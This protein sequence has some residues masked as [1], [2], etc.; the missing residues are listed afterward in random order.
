VIKIYHADIRLSRVLRGFMLELSS[1]SDTYRTILKKGILTSGFIHEIDFQNFLVEWIMWTSLLPDSCHTEIITRKSKTE[2]KT[3]NIF[4]KRN[5][6]VGVLFIFEE[7]ILCFCFDLDGIHFEPL[8]DTV[9]LS[10]SEWADL[11][12]YDLRVH[13]A[14]GY[15]LLIVDKYSKRKDNEY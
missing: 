4:S 3:L 2:F 15:I 9:E 8:S 11:W 10:F 7:P 12:I 6:A 13:G 5:G 1:V 14:I